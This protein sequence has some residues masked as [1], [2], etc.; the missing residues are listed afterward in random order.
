MAEKGHLTTFELGSISQ[1][2]PQNLFKKIGLRQASTFP[3][4]CE[5][6]D[7]D[8]FRELDDN[9]LAITPNLLATLVL[10]TFVQE[11][12]KKIKGRELTNSYNIGGD[13]FEESQR[14]IIEESFAL[15]HH[16]L[17]IQSKEVLE[18]SSEGKNSWKHIVIEFADLF[19]FC[20]SAPI[21]F[22]LKP[23]F[24]NK[25]PY[26]R[27][28]YDSCLVALLPSQY[29][30]K[31]FILFPSSQNAYVRKYLKRLGHDIKTLPS[32]ILQT[33]LE[34]CENTYFRT[35]WLTG[36]NAE[37]Q[38]IIHTVFFSDMSARELLERERI[39]SSI[40][41]VDE[42]LKIKTNTLVAKKWKQKLR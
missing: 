3:G 21:S 35:S 27:E 11:S 32:R 23:S 26:S 8:L 15:G 34:V 37:T 25:D 24:G 9:G 12:Y 41:Q 19:P 4:F 36:L 31:F 2:N 16:D 7:S 10:R 13:N 29:G 14:K 42:K 20:F 22:E 40:L 17:F 28:I 38:K 33:A 39:D 5:K 18:L 30:S 1:P 6:H